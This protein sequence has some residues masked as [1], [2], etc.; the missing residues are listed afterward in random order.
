MPWSSTENQTELKNL[1]GNALYENPKMAKL[2]STLLEQFGAKDKS[3]GILF[4]K[5]RKSTNCL[6]DWVLNNRALQRS[7]IKAAVL[8][9]AG[10]GINYMTQVLSHDTRSR[11]LY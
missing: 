8:T 6:N 9:G 10:N 5:T 3:R 2:Q 7:G 1:S 4:C 11:V